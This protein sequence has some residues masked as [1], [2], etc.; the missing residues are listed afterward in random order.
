MNKTI[1]EIYSGEF[2]SQVQKQFRKFN[3]LGAEII[4][5]RF[6]AY[7]TTMNTIQAYVDD[8]YREYGIRFD[9]AIFDYLDLMGAISGKKDETERISD[10]Y[11]DVK[12]F[13]EYNNIESGWTASHL[14]RE[15]AKKEATKYNANDI[16][17]AIDK[18]R[19]ADC[20]WGLNQS[21]EEKQEGIMRWQVVDQRQGVPDARALFWLDIPHQRLTEFSLREI[22][23]YRDQ[24]ATDN[25]EH[26]GNDL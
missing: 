25:L 21:E 6:P 3:R 9:E 17:K 26:R 4:V 10:A 2:D 24:E 20:I 1:E 15:G 13:L 8:I 7:T 19:H 11:V 18:I 22:N 16:A 5:K 14:N 12:N 23:K